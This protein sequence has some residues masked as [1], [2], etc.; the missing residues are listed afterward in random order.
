MRTIGRALCACAAILLFAAIPIPVHVHIQI[1]RSTFDALDDVAFRIIADNPTSRPMTLHYSS[2]N[3]FAIEI[4]R[5]GTVL[6]KSI[7]AYNGVAH[8]PG[9]AQM[10]FPG[11]HPIVT[12]DWNGVLANG[13]APEPGAYILRATLLAN[14]A[15]QTVSAQLRIAPPLPIQGIAHL[16]DGVPTTIAGVLSPD[17]QT[18]TDPTGHVALF[19][20]LLSLVRPGD[21]VIA[22][23]YMQRPRGGTQTFLV[24]RYAPLHRANPGP[25]ASPTPEAIPCGPRATPCRTLHLPVPTAAP[26]PHRSQ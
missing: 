5:N 18:L 20:K 2:P 23:G 12:Y 16:A 10:L 21:V 8:I 26:T 9:H 19:R 3:E 17:A 1:V 7:P 4:V 22:R 11:A 14:D 25:N 24:T 15:T 6:W 13:L